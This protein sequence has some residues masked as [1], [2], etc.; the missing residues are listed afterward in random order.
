MQGLVGPSFVVACVYA[1]LEAAVAGTGAFTTASEDTDGSA[2]AGDAPSEITG[3]IPHSLD[4]IA[5]RDG[6]IGVS[7]DELVNAFN[8]PIKIRPMAN[9]S[10]QFIGK[11]ATV[12][13]NSRGEVITGWARNS[14]GIPK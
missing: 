7:K 12:V 14:G 8:D 1:C 6:G 2:S 9:G 4:Q 11:N 10:F 5:D 3:W 13:L